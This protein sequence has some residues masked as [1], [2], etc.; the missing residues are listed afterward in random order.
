M[1]PGYNWH[2]LSIKERI[3]LVQGEQSGHLGWQYV[4]LI[5]DQDTI[6]TFRETV[7]CHAEVGNYGQVLKSG[8]GEE[9]P[10]EV[11]KWIKEQA[12]MTP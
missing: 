5:D 12:F 9:P 4:L 11:K 10:N 1:R 8:W 2:K 3:Y 7:M 6:D